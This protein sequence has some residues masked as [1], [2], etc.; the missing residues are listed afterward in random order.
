MAVRLVEA[1]E[2][3]AE[4]A[5]EK[6]VDDTVVTAKSFAPNLSGRLANSIHA[7]R[8]DRFEW[9]VKTNAEGNKGFAYPAHIEAGE[10]VVATQAKALHFRIHGREIYTKS[11]APS[12]QSGFMKKTVGYYK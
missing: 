3:M 10:G 5:M 6:F 12:S 2:D 4:E 9:L 8:L 11:T 1:M 7:V